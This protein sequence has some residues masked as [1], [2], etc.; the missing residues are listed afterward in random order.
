VEGYQLE[1]KT[2]VV[3]L[4]YDDNEHILL[5]SFAQNSQYYVEQIHYIT[6]KKVFKKYLKFEF[7]EA[8][9]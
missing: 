9:S 4:P 8:D 2:N 7:T 1:V 5:V 3:V 6:L